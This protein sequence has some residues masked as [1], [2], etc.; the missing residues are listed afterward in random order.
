MVKASYR[1]LLFTGWHRS[2][3]RG[4]AGIIRLLV[5]GSF[6]RGVAWSASCTVDVDE[7][8]DRPLAAGSDSRQSGQ[9]TAAHHPGGGDHLLDDLAGRQ[10]TGQPGLPGAVQ[11]RS[12][13][14]EP[15]PP[16]Q[17]ARLER[18]EP[19]A[20][21]IALSWSRRLPA[22]RAASSGRL[23]QNSIT[24]WVP[25]APPRRPEWS[26]GSAPGKRLPLPGSGSARSVDACASSPNTAPATN[27]SC[28]RSPGRPS[29]VQQDEPREGR[30]G[31]YPQPKMKVSGG[32]LGGSR[33][34]GRGLSWYRSGWLRWPV[35]TSSCT[36]AA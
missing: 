21:A 5:V 15:A 31:G 27:R 20:L 2:S 19:H 14:G 8:A 29:A 30:R 34:T 33:R 35:R 36:S 12:G 16:C 11:R 7:A 28:R 3:P 24:L 26:A 10:V 17:P 13:F 4:R 25:T 9:L 22:S 32:R 6:P 18:R 1:P 23:P